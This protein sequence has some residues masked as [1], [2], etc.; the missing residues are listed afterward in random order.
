MVIL[1]WLLNFDLEVSVGSLGSFRV[2]TFA[3]GWVLFSFVCDCCSCLV[4]LVSCRFVVGL[5]AVLGW[6]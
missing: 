2:M 6:C 5:F 4:V 3:G 1:V